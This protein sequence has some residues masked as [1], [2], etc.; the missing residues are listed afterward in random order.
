MRQRIF[1]AP[2]F[3]TA[4]S[5][6]TLFET[7]L[8]CTDKAYTE[9]CFLAVLVKRSLSFLPLALGRCFPLN[10][11]LVFQETGSSLL[12]AISPKPEY[13]LHTSCLPVDVAGKLFPHSI[14]VYKKKTSFPTPRIDPSLY[15]ISGREDKSSP[16]RHGREHRLETQSLHP[17]FHLTTVCWGLMVATGLSIQMQS[18]PTNSWRRETT[19]E[20][21][22]SF[23]DSL[24]TPSHLITK[25]SGMIL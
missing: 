6:L 16:S 12:T 15:G 2:R 7:Y 23:P 11:Y 1:T 17:P 8:P 4:G 9:G 21:N 19:K 18:F 22:I 10:C 3:I 13:H 24:E 25:D 20:A 14:A 5:E